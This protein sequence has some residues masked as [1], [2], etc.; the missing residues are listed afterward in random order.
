MMRLLGLL[1]ALGII[2]WILYGGSGSGRDA[3]G[4]VPEGYRQSMDQARA[5]EQSVQDAA[6]KS[7]HKLEAEDS[8]N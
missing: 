4:V 3:D 1:V 7:L 5:V 6:Q 8:Q 2:G